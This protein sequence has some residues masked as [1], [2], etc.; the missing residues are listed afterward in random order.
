M[1]EAEEEKKAEEVHAFTTP[2]GKG[3]TERS[4]ELLTKASPGF[5]SFDEKDS[6]IFD[7]SPS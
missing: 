3:G 6:S 5:P 1:T 2:P 7:Q 4:E